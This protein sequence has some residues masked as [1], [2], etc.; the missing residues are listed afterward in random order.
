[1]APVQ[2]RGRPT[3]VLSPHP[4]GPLVLSVEL[5]PADWRLAQAGLDGVPHVLAQG[6]HGR[7][8]KARALDDIATEIA[9]AYRGLTGYRDLAGRVRAVSV[10]VAGTLSDSRLVQFTTR[11]WRDVDLTVLMARLPTAA[12]LPLLLGNDATLS[13]LAEARSGSARAGSTVLHL[14]I[15]VGLGGTLVVAGEPVTGSH[16]AAGEYGHVPFG[17]PAL[18]CPCGARGCWDLT[19]DGRALARH[20]GD[21]PPPDPVVYAQAL[22]A[23]DRTPET[24]NAFDAVATSLGSGIAGL[25]NL[26]DPDIVTLGGL[27]PPLRNAAPEAFD[28]AYR[29]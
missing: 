23:A 18:E 13:G 21:P 17:D 20:L 19:V 4:D 7:I 9:A 2:G 28:T 26:H 10:S 8:G 11:G 3:T 1:P 27:A 22:L 16:G 25:V 12:G 24:Q 15:M 6:S 29:A 14:I 5:R